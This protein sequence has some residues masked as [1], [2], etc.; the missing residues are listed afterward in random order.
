MR[1]A[2]TIQWGVSGELFGFSQTQSA[3]SP[4]SLAPSFS[5]VL[6]IRNNMETVLTVFRI[7]RE[8]LCNP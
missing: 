2:T 8:M 3:S 4:L 1:E 5:W 7:G 6:A